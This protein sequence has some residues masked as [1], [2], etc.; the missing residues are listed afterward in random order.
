M[1]FEIYKKTLEGHKTFEGAM[2]SCSKLGYGWRLPTIDE[3]T[4]MYSMQEQGEITLGNYGCWGST[5]H[6]TGYVYSLGF[7]TG[8]VYLNPTSNLNLVRPVRDIQQVDKEYWG[9]E[10]PLP[11]SPSDKDVETYKENMVNGSTLMLGCTKKLI[12]ISD[13]QMDIDPW[14]ES[15]TVIKQDWLSNTTYYDNIIGDG[16]L[17]FTH[18]FA[19]KI[20]DMASK[21]CKIFIARSF[22]RKLDSMRIA[23]NFPRWSDFTIKP[24]DVET[25]DDYTFFIWLF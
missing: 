12:P 1:K 6:E 16:V 23:K 19:E 22:N 21:N 25:F 14:Y 7:L 18:E 4:D 15:E 2:E 11:L 24:S 8:N 10:L 13:I 9:S 3:L 17:N 20:I 5:I